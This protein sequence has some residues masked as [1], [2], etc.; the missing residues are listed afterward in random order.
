[1]AAH[2]F[3]TLFLAS[4]QT[5][6]IRNLV[7]AINFFKRCDSLKSID[8][9]HFGQLFRGHDYVDKQLSSYVIEL[10]S[11]KNSTLERLSFL[12]LSNKF[13]DSL[14]VSSCGTRL[15]SLCLNIPTL[16]DDS[17]AMMITRNPGLTSVRLGSC[18]GLTQTS[19]RQIQRLGSK[20]KYLGLG[21]NGLKSKAVSL[22][23][24]Y[25]D[26]LVIEI[27]AKCTSITSLHLMCCDITNRVI[28]TIPNFLLKLK[29]VTISSN[30]KITQIAP[31]LKCTNLRNFDFNG[32]EILKREAIINF[33]YGL[34]I[35]QTESLNF[36]G[37]RKLNNDIVVYIVKYFTV[38]KLLRVEECYRLTD[39]LFLPLIK[40]VKAKTKYQRLNIFVNSEK[41]SHATTTMTDRIL[42][43]T[44]GTRINPFGMDEIW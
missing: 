40:E 1:M 25:N 32:L 6:S 16:Q 42:K 36:S 11:S 20:L 37:V 7:A 14:I 21:V 13:S 10:A 33:L 31:L 19:L 3:F 28:D 43:D 12:T 35:P 39:E 2:C 38:L 17:F 4:F 29:E 15:K 9:G 5:G 8:L 44:S 30:K 23:R 27:I 22:F 26:D 41:M 24:Y 18:K 34:N